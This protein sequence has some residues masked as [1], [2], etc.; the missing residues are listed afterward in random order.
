M[1]K[2]YQNFLLD[3][4]G[5]PH[6]FVSFQDAQKVAGALGSEWKVKGMWQIK[7]WYVYSEEV[8]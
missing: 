2:R 1:P 4:N 8:R 3:R 7:T 6:T 5:L